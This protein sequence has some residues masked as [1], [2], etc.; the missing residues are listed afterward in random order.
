MVSEIAANR[1]CD[2]MSFRHLGEIKNGVEDI[3]SEAVKQWSGAQENYTLEEKDGQTELKIAMDISAVPAD[4]K[5]YF[6]KTW[7]IALRKV[8]DLAE[9]N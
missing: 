9:K 5:E 6:R 2:F 7:P 8:K 4:F 3:S 1:P